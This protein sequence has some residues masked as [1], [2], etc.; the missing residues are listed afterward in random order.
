MAPLLIGPRGPTNN[1]CSLHLNIASIL[2]LFTKFSSETIF[3][4]SSNVLASN[5][6]TGVVDRPKLS[7]RCFFEF[8]GFSMLLLV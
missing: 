3:V 6:T 4:A 5:V 7:T 2:L 8:L 1:K